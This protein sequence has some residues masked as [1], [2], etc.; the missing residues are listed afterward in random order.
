MSILHALQ[1]R[2]GPIR[3]NSPEGYVPYD[4]ATEYRRVVGDYVRTCR[5]N[6]DLTQLEVALAIG[7]G[8]TFVSNFEVGRT[9]VPPEHYEVLAKLF[10]LDPVEFA[11]FLLRWTNPWLYLMIYATTDRKLRAQLGNLGSRNGVT[12]PK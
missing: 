3:S 9:S 6:A 7:K 11:K 12:K 4:I 8:N 1:R 5:L 10:N 2:Q